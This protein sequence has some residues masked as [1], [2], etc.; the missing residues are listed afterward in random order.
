MSAAVLASPLD[1]LPIGQRDRQWIEDALAELPDEA[2]NDY[3]L[4]EYLS[5]P[6]GRSVRRAWEAALSTPLVRYADQRA[7]K[8]LDDFGWFDPIPGRQQVVDALEAA[9]QAWKEELL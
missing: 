2:I 6:H 9:A 5:S 4:D 3:D 7:A 8:T 1:A